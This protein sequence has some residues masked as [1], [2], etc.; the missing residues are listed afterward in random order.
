[1]AMTLRLTDDET[2]QLRRAAEA[3]GVSMHEF[4]RQAIA[5]SVDAWARTRDTFLADFATQNRALLD[6]LG[7]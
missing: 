5:A 2:E 6:R 4:A 1:M 3:D 7:Q